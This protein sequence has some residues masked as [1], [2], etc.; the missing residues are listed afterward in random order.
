[1]ASEEGTT[2]KKHTKCFGTEPCSVI[3]TEP[4]S[5][6]TNTPMPSEASIRPDALLRMARQGM[7]VRFAARLWSD[8]P[9]RLP[10]VVGWI[11]ARCTRTGGRLLMRTH[12]RRESQQV[13]AVLDALL[14]DDTLSEQQMARLEEDRRAIDLAFLHAMERR[15]DFSS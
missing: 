12:W 2:M 13:E 8:D 7:F 6:I 3:G 1:L 5:V 14:W 4:C 11:D 9:E 15:A 10:G